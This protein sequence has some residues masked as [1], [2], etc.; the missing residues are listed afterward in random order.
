MKDVPKLHFPA[1]LFLI[2]SLYPASMTSC[3]HDLPSTSSAIP[4]VSCVSYSA[5]SKTF[6]IWETF[7]SQDLF[8]SP[9]LYSPNS[10]EQR[11]S[12]GLS[13]SLCALNP[14]IP[15]RLWQLHSD[16]SQKLQT[17]HVQNVFHDLIPGTIIYISGAQASEQSQIC[18][19]LPYFLYPIIKSC[20]F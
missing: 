3:C 13:I 8:S 20:P 12:P 5:C 18:L 11:L 15:L 17:Q 14:H 9:S 6:H 16:V 1:I 4:S 10:S 7:S 19:L 2:W